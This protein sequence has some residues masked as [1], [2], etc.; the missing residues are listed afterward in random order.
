[1]LTIL[2]NYDL[3]P[4]AETGHP[5][6][7]VVIQGINEKEWQSFISAGIE[8]VHS[9]GPAHLRGLSCLVYTF[10]LLKEFRRARL[11]C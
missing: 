1:M 9:R 3:V 4:V 2:K 5:V 8:R 10:H 6:W 11:V 7:D